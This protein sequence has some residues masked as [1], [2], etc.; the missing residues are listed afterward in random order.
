MSKEEQIRHVLLTVWDP[1]GV[2][3]FDLPDDEY[4]SYIQLFEDLM[5]DSLDPAHYIQLIKMIEREF[6][7]FSDVL[8]EKRAADIERTAKKMVAIARQWM[9]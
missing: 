1:I 5:E 7:S 3:D 8:I 6:F 9:I 4:D 2:S